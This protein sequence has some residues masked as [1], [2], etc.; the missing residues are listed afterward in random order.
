M[1]ILQRNGDLVNKGGAQEFYGSDRRPVIRVARDRHGIV[2][3]TD[4]GSDRVA[5]RKR[6]MIAPERLQYLEPNVP[7]A[8]PDV[9]RIPNAKVDVT[10]IQATVIQDAKM[11]IWHE[12][13]R[14]LSRHNPDESEPDTA[15]CQSLRR[16][17]KRL[18]CG[19][20]HGRVERVIMQVW[21]SCR[22]G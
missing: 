16:N 6:I 12:T 15:E 7:G 20:C 9:L 2:N 22:L 3:R 4:E 14:W 11:I 10:D 1:W 8:K 13:P 18:L 21:L 5:R 19:G 17:G